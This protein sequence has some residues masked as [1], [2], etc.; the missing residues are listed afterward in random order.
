MAAK[1]EVNL[2]HELSLLLKERGIPTRIGASIYRP[3]RDARAVPISYVAVQQTSYLSSLSLFKPVSPLSIQGC[4]QSRNTS[5]TMS[6]ATANMWCEEKR[7]ASLRCL[8]EALRNDCVP[9]LVSQ[10]Q[11]LGRRNAQQRLHSIERRRRVKF[12]RKPQYPVQ[13]SCSSV[14]IAKAEKL[15]MATDPRLFSPPKVSSE[16][17]AHSL[18]TFTRSSCL[19]R[20]RALNT[21]RDQLCQM[22]INLNS[23]HFWRYH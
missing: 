12:P 13:T 2:I 10:N 5:C 17:L 11:S 8:R 22:L 21:M 23:Y 14:R 6:K 20:H 1:M 3:S 15:H 9:M 18:K 4:L 16:I 7:F 19:W